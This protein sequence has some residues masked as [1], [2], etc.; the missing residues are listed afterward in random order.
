M[1]AVRCLSVAF[2]QEPTNVTVQPMGYAT[3][4][5][6]GT[7][8]S[9]TPIGTIYGFEEAQGTNYLFFQWYKNGVA[10]P[11]ANSKSI[12]LGPLVPS[13]NGAQIYCTMRALGYANDALT[14]IWSNSVTATITISPQAVFEPGLLKEDWW[15]NITSRLLVENGS[16]GNPHFLGPV[17]TLA[18]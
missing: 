1:S 8:D 2:T 12:T 3:F 15:T 14:P 9:T 16:V 13:D 18:L 4:S 6:T 11:G 10:I 5:A 17:S 7:T